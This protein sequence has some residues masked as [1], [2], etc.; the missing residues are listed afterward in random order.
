[1]SIKPA[2]PLVVFF[3]LNL[4]GC[5]LTGFDPIDDLFSPPKTCKQDFVF[6][7]TS[8]EPLKVS[9][10]YYEGSDE[11]RCDPYESESA[12]TLAPGASTQMHLEMK[13]R[14]CY[15]H[16]YASA[17]KIADFGIGYTSFRSL[18]DAAKLPV[19]FQ[20]KVVSY[21]KTLQK[22]ITVVEA[23]PTPNSSNRV[24]WPTPSI[25]APQVAWLYGR[26]L[27]VIM[28]KEFKSMNPN[29]AF[30]KNTG[31]SDFGNFMVR[32]ENGYYVS[33][34]DYQDGFP[35]G[36]YVLSDRTRIICDGVSC[37]SSNF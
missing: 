36:A 5:G 6:K 3:G 8:S 29:I 28:P 11:N 22:D 25:L 27:Y 14:S 23:T 9:G 18:D 31:L 2:I 35:I 7:N 20:F 10:G 12:K 19:G 15:N 17:T 33:V 26:T 32:D 16:A 34:M 37:T 24:Y 1:M 13:C 30:P 4:L 21:D